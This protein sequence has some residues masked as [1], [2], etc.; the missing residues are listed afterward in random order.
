MA[1]SP[2]F[3]LIWLLLYERR[4]PKKV[5]VI[6]LVIVIFGAFT[7]ATGGSIDSLAMPLPAS[8]DAVATKDVADMVMV[9]DMEEL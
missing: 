4:A 8:V 7:L 9:M 1:A 2:I 3:V 5:E 6:V